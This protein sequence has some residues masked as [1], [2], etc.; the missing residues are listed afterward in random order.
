MYALAER[1]ASGDHFWV[2]TAPSTVQTA[3][4]PLNSHECIMTGNGDD[5][6]KRDESSADGSG[7]PTVTP[8][9]DPAFAATIGTDTPTASPIQFRRSFGD[10]ELLEELAR[11]GMGV[12]FKARQISLNRIVALKMILSG[13]LASEADVQRFRQEA[14]AAANLEHPNVLPIHDVG[15][16]D[17]QHFFTM[18]LVHG[19]NL[20]DRIQQLVNDPPAAMRLMEQV[21]RGVH[22]AHQRGILH[23]DLKPANVLIDA[24]GTPYVT[25]FGLAKFTEADSSLTQSGAILGTPSY[26]APEQAR[27]AKGITTA[28]DVYSLG[29]IIYQL[30]TGRPPFKGESVAVTLRMVEEEEP[31]PPRRHNAECDPDL[32]AVTLKCLE[33]DPVRRYETAGAL[34]D[35]LR[36]WQAGEPVTARR[37]GTGRRA[38]KWVKRNPA[39]AALAVFCVLI[40]LGG[41]GLS[42][43]YGVKAS[44]Q[45]KLTAD[46]AERARVSARDATAASEQAKDALCRGSFD[47][48]RALRLAGQPGWRDRSLELVRKSAELRARTR[49]DGSDPP[50][51]MPT[52]TDLRTE[53]VSALLRADPRLVRDIVTPLGIVAPHVSRDGRRIFQMQSELTEPVRMELRQLDA[54]TGEVVS[55]TEIKLDVKSPDF[56]G[57]TM[58]LLNIQDQNRDGSR[59]VTT[60]GGVQIRELPTGRLVVSLT[61]PPTKDESPL[62]PYFRARISPDGLRVAVIRKVKNEAQLVAWD[63]DKPGAPRIIARQELPVPPKDDAFAAYRDP[64][65]FAGLSFTPDSKRLS[66]ATGDRDAYRVVD[67]TVDPPKVALELPISEKFVTAEWHPTASV[68]AVTETTQFQRQR[69]VL[70][71]VDQKAE[72]AVCGEDRL[73]S[74]EFGAPGIGPHLAVAFSPDGQWLAV[75]GSDSIV[76]IYEALDGGEL[77]RMDL[78]STFV[79]GIQLLFWNHRNELVTSGILQGLKIWDMGFPA[80][81]K[82]YPQLRP[83]DRPAFSPDGRWLAVFAPTGKLD[84]EGKDKFGRQR[85]SGVLKDRVALIDRQSGQVARFLPGNNNIGGRLFFSPDGQRLVFERN[86]EVLVRS[87]ETGDEVLR[88]GIRGGGLMRQRQSAFFEPGGRLLAFAQVDRGKAK[89]PKMNLVLWDLADDR[90][91]PGFP[92]FPDTD[93]GPVE[94]VVA[95]DG[96]RVLIDENSFGLKAKKG[97]E[98]SPER[99]FDVPSG[100]LSGEIRLQSAAEPEFFGP[101]RLGPGG[102]RLLRLQV[103]FT[104]M[105]SGRATVGD[106]NWTVHELS[107]GEQLLRIANWGMADD[108]NDISPDGSLVAL[109][110][111]R[112]YVELWDVVARAVLFRWQ[113]HGGRPVTHLSIGPNGDVATVAQGESGLTVLRLAEVR[114]K[115]TELGLGW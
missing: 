103:P 2:A 3:T 64:E 91:V 83:A 59:A 86:E 47:Q 65:T 89:A 30:L 87:V 112:G 81:S 1:S 28:A 9:P 4:D 62:S 31:T 94:A 21:A 45:A 84:P 24:D 15:E 20:G 74:T 6:T 17:G 18:K 88:R 114:A 32:E 85:G 98:L 96:S 107:S 75:G 110:V 8:P 36:R 34:A 49:D 12:V 63:A 73:V 39:V 102:R 76:H 79:L 68:L 58:T 27:G 92:E 42:S 43:Y 22:F 29:A 35:D 80:G 41:A 82:S 51:D 106:V 46:E 100:R 111:E 70:W 108:A 26:I 52:L 14:E 95:A 67:M 90:P 11:G 78:S 54:A 55:R 72:V 38:W 60:G 113:P 56:S 7:A 16:H 50:D 10:Y 53:A 48:A 40:L 93:F 104:K 99:L 97:Q 25:D 23:R 77:A 71:D 33:K 105:T 57:E 109:G 101:G 61:H 69:L 115:L 19:G 13:R 5:L 44:R 37:A 66:F